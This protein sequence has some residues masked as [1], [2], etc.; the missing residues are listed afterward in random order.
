MMPVVLDGRLAEP[1]LLGE[2]VEEPSRASVE[3]SASP[4]RA[5]STA[6]VGNSESQH[7]LDRVACRA[8][9]LLPR[10]HRSARVAVL[11]RPPLH[12]R[13]D[14]REKLFDARRSPLAS[15]ISELDQ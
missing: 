11:L 1:A 14:M 10:R 6:E 8:R 2:V 4:S 13:V 15:E 5:T 12:E 7:L 9:D 3:W